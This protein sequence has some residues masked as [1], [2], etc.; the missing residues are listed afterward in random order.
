MMYL[1]KFVK[2]IPLPILYPDKKGRVHVDLVKFPKDSLFLLRFTCYIESSERLNFIEDV[3]NYIL[4]NNI[5]TY[6]LFDLAL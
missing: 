3:I 5:G 2:T 4:D 1:N 6:Y